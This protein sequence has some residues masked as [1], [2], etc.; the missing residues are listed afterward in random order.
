MPQLEKQQRCPKCGHQANLMMQ[1][2][3]ETLP[4]LTSDGHPVYSCLN[5]ACN[6]TFIDQEGKGDQERGERQQ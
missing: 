4:T 2:G 5:P 1:L 6:H 3:N